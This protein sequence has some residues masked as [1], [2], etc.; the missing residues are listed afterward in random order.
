MLTDIQIKELKAKYGEDLE[1][2]TIDTENGKTVEYVIR[3]PTRSVIEA[4]SENEE[5]NN[6]NRESAK[7]LIAN[8]VV[9]GD[10]EFI[11]KMVKYI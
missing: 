6:G 4:I 9:F 10:T 11:D 3:T 8:C 5:K 1:L 2:I 7:I